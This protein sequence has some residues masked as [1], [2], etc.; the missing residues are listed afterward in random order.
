[1]LRQLQLLQCFSGFTGNSSNL[2]PVSTRKSISH[3]QVPSDLQVIGVHSRRSSLF[4]TMTAQTSSASM[5]TFRVDCFDSRYE[6]I[7]QYFACM[8]VCDRDDQKC[9]NNC[10]DRHMNFAN[11]EDFS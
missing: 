1:M 2:L 7:D 3:H 11:N 6:A 4:R 5:S 8:I 9:L 10:L